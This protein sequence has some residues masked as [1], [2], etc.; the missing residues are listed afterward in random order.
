MPFNSQFTPT[1]GLLNTSAFPTQPA[2]EEAARQQFMDLFNL[3]L[4]N[5]NF[6]DSA[7]A[8]FMNYCYVRSSVNI[9][10]ADSTYTAIPLDTN[11]KDPKDM[12]S[13]TINNTHITILESGNY[14][15][16]GIIVYAS[17]ATG[18]REAYI[19]LNGGDDIAGSSVPATGSNQ[20]VI[21]STIRYLDAGDYIELIGLQTSTT[22][23]NA[24]TTFG[25]APSLSAQRI[26]G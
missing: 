2:S 10:L 8:D 9:S 25:Y 4:G 16:N 1:D 14:A 5:D 6:L 7:L 17:S 21:V 23:L 18:R 24:L 22:P 13:T 3:L 19:K 12:H 15:I 20:G 26:G 11:A